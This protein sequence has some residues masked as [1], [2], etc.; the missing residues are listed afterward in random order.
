VEARRRRLE[1]LLRIASRQ[2]GLHLSFGKADRVGGEG[3]ALR[4]E[5]RQVTAAPYLTLKGGA[6][7]LLGHHLSSSGAALEA[8]DAEE[9]SGKPGFAALWHALED[10]RIE[11][12]MVRRWP[13]MSKAFDARLAPGH[14]GRLLRLAPA[15]QQIEVGIYEL[16]RGRME[17]DLREPIREAL[18]QAGGWI[19]EGASAPDADG[20]LAAMRRI[21]PHLSHLLR[22]TPQRGRAQET[23]EAGPRAQKEEPISG[24]GP[25]A[26]EPSGVPEIELGADLASAGLLGRRR[27][28]PEWYRPG[29]AP[30]FERGLGEKRVHP[31][32]ARADAQ[33]IVRPAP[34]DPRQYHALLRE[35]RREAGHL[36][37]RLTHLLRE[38]AYL[39]YGGRFRS[40]KL[41]T[42]KLWKQRMGV[43]R[44]FERPSPGGRSTAF[45]VLVDESASMQGKGKARGAAKTAILLGETLDRLGAP[46]EIIGYSTGDFEARAAMRLGLTPAYEYRTMRCSLLEHRIYKGFDEPFSLVRRRL[47]DIQPRHNN[48]DE[49]SLLFAWRR[50]RAR[51]ERGKVILVISDGQPNG[52]AEHLIRAVAGIERLGCRVIGLGIGDDFVRQIYRSAVVVEDLRQMGEE[53]LGLMARELLGSARARGTGAYA[54]PRRTEAGASSGQRMGL[55]APD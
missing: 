28:L 48:W 44:L 17:Q 39:R 9:A 55:A 15:V 12:A 43:Y 7:H 25:D 51:R 24:K 29:S 37:G 18:R 36:E 30:W 54:R 45:T 26:S 53:L 10:A 3:I 13:G 49:E 31:S 47:S 5:P 52:D 27:E 2:F 4:A 34:G 16:G 11:N 50:I 23:A 41:R 35:V 38:E 1:T 14:R 40:G 33:T 42:A 8:A 6:L 21:Y 22:G 32:V 20:S 46:F 19:A